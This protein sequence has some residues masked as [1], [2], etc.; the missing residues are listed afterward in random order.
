MTTD[1]PLHLIFKTNKLKNWKLGEG[2]YM[3]I[4]LRPL[5]HMCNSLSVVSAYFL[6]LQLL[7]TIQPSRKILRAAHC[8]VSHQ[9]PQ[10]KKLTKQSMKWL[11]CLGKES[12]EEVGEELRKK[13][14][15]FQNSSNWLCFV[16]NY[17]LGGAVE[18]NLPPSNLRIG[19][20][21]CNALKQFHMTGYNPYIEGL[22]MA[23]ELPLWW[24]SAMISATSTA[25]ETSVMI[26]CVQLTING[27]TGP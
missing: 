23:W 21:S 25:G 2:L 12:D 6:S 13:R 19:E 4:Q 16:Q 15:K 24:L 27:K 22:K 1:F 10:T 3:C 14:W 11:C 8:S 26:F 18:S 17:R 7:N 5:P 9:T 20:R